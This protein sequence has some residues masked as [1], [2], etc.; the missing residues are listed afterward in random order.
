MLIPG[1]RLRELLATGQPV[2]DHFT[3][4]EG[5]EVLSRY[6]AAETSGGA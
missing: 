6:Y 5:L 4:P 1:T 3:R 2:P